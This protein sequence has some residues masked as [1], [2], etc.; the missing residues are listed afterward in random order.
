MIF[1]LK[2]AALASAGLL[3]LTLS[4]VRAEPKSAV[5]R[6][7]YDAARKEANAKGLPLF[8]KV[9]SEACIHCQRL[10]AGPLR[11][12]GVV[13]LLN[14]RFVPL[15]V[16]AVKAPKLIET[17]RI[18]AFPTMIIAANDG[19][20]LTFLEGYQE[21]KALTDHMQ[22][23]L[24]AQT[25]DWMARDYQEASKAIA[26]G[27]YAKAVPLLKGILQDGKDLP[28][29]TKSKA[30]LD[31]VEQQAA[32]RLVR[33]RQFGD[34]GQHAEA[35]DLLTELLSRYPGTGAA[36]DGAKML[37]RLAERPEMK[38]DHRGRR[39]QDLLAQ[40]REAF[41]GEKFSAALELCQILETTYKDLDEG[42]QGAQLA[43]EIRSSP[44]KL[45]LACEHLN[46]RLASMYATLGDTWLKKGEKEQA[47][48]CYE[49]AVRA[50]PASLAAREAQA[51]LTSLIVK[52]PTITSEFRKPQK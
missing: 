49:K 40:A 27:D 5:W 8:L 19:R 43:A 9:Y 28:I 23:A 50:A 32:G 16:E 18:Q 30:V 12:P 10:D 36:A 14:E 33:V 51:K 41:K 47:A 1:R 44:E 37:S 35:M 26:A 29:Q 24:A 45:A 3:L 20:I 31:E 48:A 7:D 13:T 21:A 46:E 39:A 6:T 52:S 34:K 11:D 2:S 42:G 25:P 17:L 38:A 4:P 22:R 15:L